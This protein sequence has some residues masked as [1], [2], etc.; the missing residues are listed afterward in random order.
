MHTVMIKNSTSVGH[1]ITPKNCSSIKFGTDSKK[2]KKPIPKILSTLL[3]GKGA[4][5]HRYSQSDGLLT[6]VCL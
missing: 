1:Y 4:T 2:L 6:V 5:D 3:I